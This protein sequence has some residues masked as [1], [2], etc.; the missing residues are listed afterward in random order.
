M[1]RL[2]NQKNQ[3]F[4]IH[5]FAECAINRPQTV[6]LLVGGGEARETLEES[7]VHCDFGEHVCFTGESDRIAALLRAMDVLAVSSLSEG[8]GIVALEAQVSGLPVICSSGVLE[9]VRGAV[10]NSPF[11][12]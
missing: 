9:E 12:E 10:K 1:G 4:L 11:G 2:E 8:L 3:I 7:A 5:V 6:L